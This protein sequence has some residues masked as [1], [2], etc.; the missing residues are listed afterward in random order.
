MSTTNVLPIYIDTYQFVREVYLIT[1]KFPREFKYCLGEQINRDVL[2]LL[3]EIF[4]AN[5]LPDERV[6]HLSRFLAS[7]DMV[8]VELRLGHDMKVLSTRQM[9]HLA[10]FLDKIVKQAT[11]WQKYHKSHHNKQEDTKKVLPESELI[12]G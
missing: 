1:H 6:M 10:Q 5:H 11:S 2:V 3:Y 4:Q 8:R 9:A 12:T 7:L